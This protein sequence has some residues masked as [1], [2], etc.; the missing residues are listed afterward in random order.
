MSD[1][2][3]L[4]ISTAVISVHVVKVDGHKMTKA[5]FRQIPVVA[6]DK[7]PG[8]MSCLGWVNEGKDHKWLLHSKDGKLFRTNIARWET[9]YPDGS[10]VPTAD[11]LRQLFIAT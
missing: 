10:K 2:K 9:T 5:T 11:R 3:R 1:E 6:L 8:D 7:W 4:S